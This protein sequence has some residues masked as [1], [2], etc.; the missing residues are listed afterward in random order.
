MCHVCSLW[1]MVCCLSILVVGLV[2]VIGDR[3]CWWF[4]RRWRARS[5]TGE[6]MFV[7]R[8]MPLFTPDGSEPW[9]WQPWW[10]YLQGGHQKSRLRFH[11]WKSILYCLQFRFHIVWSWPPHQWKGHV[12][13]DIDIVRKQ[14]RLNSHYLHM[15]VYGHQPNSRVYIPI[16]R[17]PY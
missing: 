8:P 14:R 7:D 5:G 13:C 3:R 16:K 9:S 1:I 11:F 15:I 17:I 6:W 4:A 12:P 2:I 10:W